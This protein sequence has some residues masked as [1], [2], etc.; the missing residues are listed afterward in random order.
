MANAILY[1]KNE[2]N[3]TIV[4]F[5]KEVKTTIKTPLKV[6]KMLCEQ[7]LFSYESRIRLT[8][9]KLKI[10]T[11]IPV[12]ITRK[13]LLMPILSP[14]RYENIWINYYQVFN[15]KGKGL[16]TLVLFNNLV[17]LA[18]DI[19]YAVFKKVIEKAQKT[20]AYFCLLKVG[21]NLF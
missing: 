21:E 3:K 5:T 2:G 17:E 14:K 6:V 1:I 13:I 4:A 7:K 15:Y 10:S 8:K 18:I 11:K 20:D 19:R 12:Y 9:E 16:K